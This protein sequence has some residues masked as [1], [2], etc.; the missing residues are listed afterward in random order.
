[1]RPPTPREF[2]EKYKNDPEEAKR[3][4]FQI[5]KE[6]GQSLKQ[7]YNRKGEGLES[8]AELLNDFMRNVMEE[9]SARVE[10]NKVIIRSAGFCA[11]MRAALTLNI[12]WEWL[13][14]NYA[15]PSL[16]GIASTIIPDIKQKIPS[17]RCRGDSACIHIFETE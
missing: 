16:H 2:Y 10:G 17:A 3:A 8:V 7:K 12:P 15:W 9:P 13:D 1:M 14:A 11:I 4:A 6:T 5:G